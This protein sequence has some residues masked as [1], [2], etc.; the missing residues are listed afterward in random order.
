VLLGGHPFADRFDDLLRIWPTAA[1]QA[2]EH[3]GLPFGDDLA[4]GDHLKLADCA[5]DALRGD[6]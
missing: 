4:V 2:L 1:N 3:A 5:G 6:P